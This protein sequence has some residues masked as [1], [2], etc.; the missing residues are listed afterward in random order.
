ML[1]VAGP[2]GQC[3]EP[4]AEVVRA[5]REQRERLITHL[6]VDNGCARAVMST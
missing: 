2:C 3:H 6:V 5:I 4:K 1:L